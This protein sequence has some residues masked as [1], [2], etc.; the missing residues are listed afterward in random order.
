MFSQ[1]SVIPSVMGGGGIPACNWAGVSAQRSTWG[2]SAQGMSAQGGVCP[3]G[4]SNGGVSA[5][6]GLPRGG[7]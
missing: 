1:A 6:D 5:R 3:G 2:M 7:V 4:L